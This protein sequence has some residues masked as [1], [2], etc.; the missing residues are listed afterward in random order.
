MGTGRPRS[1]PAFSVGGLSTRQRILRSQQNREGREGGG[2]PGGEPPE[3][4]P[5]W[6]D[7]PSRAAVL[8]EPRRRAPGGRRPPS[9][10]RFRSFPASWFHSCR[11]VFKSRFTV[12]LASAQQHF[13]SFRYMR[14]SCL[15]WQMADRYSCQRL[16]PP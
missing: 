11:V 5:S 13:R 1:R 16:S 3:T 12:G 15:Q 6:R 14:L 2:G 9:C 7:A 4:G 8:P 10:P